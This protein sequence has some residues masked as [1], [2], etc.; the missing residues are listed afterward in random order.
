MANNSFTAAGDKETQIAFTKS[1]IDSYNTALSHYDFVLEDISSEI[2]NPKLQTSKGP[3]I[4]FLKEMRNEWAK[5]RTEAERTLAQ[6][7]RG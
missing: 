7:R 1:V 6:L 5:C 4:A 3:A 2:Y